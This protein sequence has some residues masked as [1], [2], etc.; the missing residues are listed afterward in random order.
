MTM[1]SIATTAERCLIAAYR[2]ERE[3]KATMHQLAGVLVR[4]GVVNRYGISVETP[5]GSRMWAV[6][7]TD[8]ASAEGS[9]DAWERALMSLNLAA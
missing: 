7:L 2:T 9:P 6:Y 5:L 4:C 1:E 3:A 8:R